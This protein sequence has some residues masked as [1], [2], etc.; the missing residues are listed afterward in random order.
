M[1][2]IEVATRAQV[3][4]SGSGSAALDGTTLSVRGSFGGMQGP[5]T[6][7]RIHQGPMT[8]V[9]GPALFELKIE[10]NP[11]GTF[12]GEFVLTAKL[13]E[14]LRQGRMYIQIHS[15]SAPDGN[16]WGWLLP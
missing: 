10:P 13:I 14:S 16:L 6:V 5:A 8:S 3:T 12:T 9:R 15:E 4:G 2:P 7:A 11:T 1:M